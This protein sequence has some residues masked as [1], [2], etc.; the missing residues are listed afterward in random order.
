MCNNGYH[1]IHHNKAGLHW[2]KL[3]AAHDEEVKP[4]IDPSLDEPSMVW[5]L[6]RT[7]LL[8]PGRPARKNVAEAERLA[9]SI[10]LAS[11]D[12]R[13]REAAEQAGVTGV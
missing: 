3:D 8:Q 9:P 6:L 4:R 2:S 11:R 12:R 1:T 7:Y 5:Y 10:D 13:R